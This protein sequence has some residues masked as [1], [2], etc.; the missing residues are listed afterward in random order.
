MAA[1]ETSPRQRTRCS[2]HCSWT[3][4][5]CSVERAGRGHR[6]YQHRRPV[7]RTRRARRIPGGLSGSSYW[8]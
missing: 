4:S 2:F 8:P 7:S 5:P 6:R 3:G 1:S